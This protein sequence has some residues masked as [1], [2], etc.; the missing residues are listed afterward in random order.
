MNMDNEKF[1][2]LIN[3][4]IEYYKKINPDKPL[5]NMFDEINYDVPTSTNHIME[6]F[7]EDLLKY[8]NFNNDIYES[9]D[10][11]DINK[12]DELFL[13]N[14]DNNPKYVSESVL[15]L[16]ILINNENINN[17]NIVNLK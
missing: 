16:L 12:V 2:N 14:I 6:M 15:S 8:N 17:W 9:V 13:L 5:K 1:S 4:Y 3:K 11:I 10:D 7:Y